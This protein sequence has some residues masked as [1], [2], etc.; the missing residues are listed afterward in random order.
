ME[1]LSVMFIGILLQSRKPQLSQ[2]LLWFLREETFKR[3]TSL[4][5]LLLCCVAYSAY[6]SS[7]LCTSISF[8]DH[9]RVCNT[10]YDHSETKEKRMDIKSV[11]VLI[12]QFINLWIAFINKEINWF[13]KA[14]STQL[15]GGEEICCFSKFHVSRRNNQDKGNALR[16]NSY[17]KN[18]EILQDF[19]LAPINIHGLY[20]QP[21][22]WIGCNKMWNLEMDYL[23]WM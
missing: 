14:I 17:R 2:I 18:F 1:R 9:S 10:T 11:R 23:R 15:H 12:I 7:M 4:N 5:V 21:L 20:I 16:V 6:M 13:W 8:S 3:I 22:L 19:M